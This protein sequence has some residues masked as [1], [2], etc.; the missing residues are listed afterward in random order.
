[1]SRKY[2]AKTDRNQR[3]IVGA[4]RSVGASVDTCHAVGA[5]FPDLAV[6]FRG[7]NYFLEVKDGL[8]PPSDRKLT[9]AQV[10]WHGAWRGQ[11]V[12]VTSVDE[13]LRVIGV[14]SYRDLHKSMVGEVSE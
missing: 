3:E 9:D 11:V 6:G 1:M 4:L 10:E 2:A 14:Q 7:V 13:A 12:V 5:G 8:L